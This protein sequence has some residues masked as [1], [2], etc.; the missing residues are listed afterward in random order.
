[1]VIS[2]QES[3]P[4][5]MWWGGTDRVYIRKQRLK[6][7]LKV[8]SL[9]ANLPII[10]SYNHDLGLEILSKTS[11]QLIT[12]RH[13]AQAS[14]LV[15]LH[16]RNPT[17][18]AESPLDKVSKSH[19]NGVKGHKKTDSNSSSTAWSTQTNDTNRQKTPE[20]VN[21]NPTRKDNHSKR[22]GSEF[23]GLGSHLK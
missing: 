22:D 5:R 15:S 18:R 23:G 14:C 7:V 4:S 3:S 6:S 17:L 2:K 9:A 13:S 10:S 21:K 1:M 19:P 12:T 11:L 8:E 16:N 20:K